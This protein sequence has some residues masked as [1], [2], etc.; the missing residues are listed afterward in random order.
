MRHA[1]IVG[2][3]LLGACIP[4]RHD[5]QTTTFT[6]GLSPDT[7]LRVAA[8]Q[9]EH[10]GFTVHDAGNRTIITVPRELP[11]DVRLASTAPSSRQWLVRVNAD[12]VFFGGGTRITV[13]AFLL[14]STV[15]PTSGNVAVQSAIKVDEDTNPQ[16]YRELVATAGWLEDA[17][18]REVKGNY[19]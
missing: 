17:M 14:P 7:A 6:V 11:S 18:L 4:F 1:A 3:L 13:D 5:V 8:T 2:L 15:Y 12:R 9:L 10:H 19:R 16:A